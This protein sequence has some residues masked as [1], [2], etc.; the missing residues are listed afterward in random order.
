MPHITI[1]LSANGPCIDIEVGV[2]IP[3]EDALKKSKAT[4]PSRVKVRGLIDTGASCTAIDPGIITQLGVPAT[5][6]TSIQTPSTG[7]TS[8]P[9]QQFDVSIFLIHPNFIFQLPAL[10]VVACP[11]KHQG[12]QALI[13]RDI[14]SNCLFFYN[15]DV[16]R[17][18]LAF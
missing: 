2:S 13:G 15:G 6:S 7:T 9:C 1:D 5:G 11:L 14:L 10:P 17:F 18:A 4:I 8:H 12:I 16:K 3:R